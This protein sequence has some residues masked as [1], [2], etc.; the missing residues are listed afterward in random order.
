MATFSRFIWLFL[1]FIILIGTAVYIPFKL[2]DDKGY[3]R[4]ERISAELEM[5]KEQNRRIKK[6]NDT[7]RGQIKSISSDPDF[8]ENIARNEMGMIAKDDII[9]QF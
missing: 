5:L 3:D 7:I 9:Y 6:E 4:V 8:I 1:P 2:N